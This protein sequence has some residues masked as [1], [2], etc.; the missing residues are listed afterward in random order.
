MSLAVLVRALCEKVKFC[1][2]S[3]WK[4]MKISSLESLDCI[5]VWSFPGG[6]EM[7]RLMLLTVWILCFFLCRCEVCRHWKQCADEPRTRC[8]W[9]WFHWPSGWR[10]GRWRLQSVSRKSLSGM[11]P[12]KLTWWQFN[13]SFS[14][15]MKDPVQFNNLYEG[16]NTG[17]K[18][19]IFLYHISSLKAIFPSW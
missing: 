3:N 14:C 16:A 11:L 6:S 15:L 7:N 17:M 10:W 19:L 5:K 4:S 13:M 9:L 8:I 12:F 1:W 2:H 18:R